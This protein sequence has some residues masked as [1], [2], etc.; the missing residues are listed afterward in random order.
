MLTQLRLHREIIAMEEFTLASVK[1]MAYRLIPN[2]IGEMRGFMTS[3]KPSQSAIQLTSKQKDFVKAISKH[4]YLDLTP[5]QIFVPEGLN[6]SYN[7][8]CEALKPSVQYVSTIL[9]VLGDYKTYIS[10]LLSSE[11]EVK[12]TDYAKF[13]FE[14]LSGSIEKL[15]ASTGKCFKKND[16]TTE[17]KYGTALHNNNEWAEVFS[18]VNEMVTTIEAIKRT[19]MLKM[20][21]DTS[22]LLDMLQNKIKRHEIDNIS[23][24]MLAKISDYTYVVACHLE[25]YSVTYFRTKT[26]AESINQTVDKVEGIINR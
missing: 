10:R 11:D 2:I 16:H 26:L 19:E 8:Y 22:K 4:A 6:V 1:E 14:S 20:I 23:Y 9:T 24:E 12:S 18:Q 25:F 21:E 13:K 17:V 5:L 7:E 15:S 3:I